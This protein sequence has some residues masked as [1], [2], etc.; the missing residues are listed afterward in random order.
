MIDAYLASVRAALGRTRAE[1]FL[2]EVRDHLVEA[3]TAGLQRGLDQAAAE[4][5]A[6]DLF[7]PPELVARHY[8]AELAEA[9]WAN[10]G[11]TLRFV[12]IACALLTLYYARFFI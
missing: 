11:Q 10:R 3:T 1:R 12:A 6:I 8:V 4:A 9:A 2:A 5:R 7:G